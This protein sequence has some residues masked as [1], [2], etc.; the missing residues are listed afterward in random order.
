VCALGAGAI[1]SA[2]F[3]TYD[4]VVE[5]LGFAALVAAAALD[6]YLLYRAEL[7]P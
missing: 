5:A 2:M 6:L 3:G 7:C 1:V 4:P